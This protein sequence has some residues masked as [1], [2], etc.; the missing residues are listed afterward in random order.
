[1]C[2]IHR[3]AYPCTSVPFA[4][5]GPVTTLPSEGVAL[6]TRAYWLEILKVW[7]LAIQRQKHA[8]LRHHESIEWSDLSVKIMA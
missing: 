1:M 4:I 3:T 7:N 6:E 8:R 5:T 2:K